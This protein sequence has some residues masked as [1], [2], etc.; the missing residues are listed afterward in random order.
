MNEPVIEQRTITIRADGKPDPDNHMALRQLL[1][2]GW[3]IWQ[4]TV[5]A[6]P[7]EVEFVLVKKTGDENK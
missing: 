1:S 2:D 3:L 6:D 4:R 5:R 7:P